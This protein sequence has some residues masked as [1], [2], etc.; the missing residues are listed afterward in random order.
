MQTDL[1]PHLLIPTCTQCDEI[2][3][4]EM[5]ELLCDIETQFG[6]ALL[7]EFLFAYGGRQYSVSVRPTEERKASRLWPVHEFM[8]SRC[9]AGDI[10]IPMGTVAFTVRLA[11]TIALR[12]RDGWS[13]AEI[14][15]AVGCDTRTVSHHKKR[16]T[17]IGWLRAAL[18]HPERQAS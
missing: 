15:R 9:I 14:A 4:R 17:K 12:L 1:T 10:S 3:L 16:L 5:P 7:T 11:W 2:A 6:T 13:L 18:P 8:R